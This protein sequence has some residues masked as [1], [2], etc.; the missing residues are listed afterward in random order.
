M[1]RLNKSVATELGIT[2]RTVK[3]HRH[4]VMTKMGARSLAELVP[5][6]AAYVAATKHAAGLADAAV[7]DAAAGFAA[8]PEPHGRYFQNDGIHLSEAGNAEMAN[9]VSRCLLQVK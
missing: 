7:C 2:E 6:H 8:L 4:E 3:A 5:L 9:I 1:D